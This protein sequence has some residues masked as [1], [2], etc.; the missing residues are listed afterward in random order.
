MKFGICCAPGALGSVESLL[1]V[2]AQAGADYVEWAIGSL[3]A[4]KAN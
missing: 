4:S 3:M 1:D 2:M